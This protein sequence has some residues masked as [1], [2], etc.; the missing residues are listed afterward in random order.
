MQAQIRCDENPFE[1]SHEKFLELVEQLQTTKTRTMQLGELETFVETEGREVLRLMLEEHIRFRGIGDIGPFVKGTDGV[2]RSHRRER[3]I[4]MRTIFGEVTI[5]RLVYG[6]R[7][8]ESLAPKD[9]ALN[10]PEN[11]YSHGLE[12]RLAIEIAKG[13]FDEAI[14]SVKGQTG[15]EIPKRQA[16]EIAARAARDFEVFYEKRSTDAL[17]RTTKEN[18]L[19]V[20]TTDGKGVVMR[21]EDLRDATRK[22]AEKEKKLRTR[23]SK[24][25]KKNAK[26]MAQVASVY[27]IERHERT[28]EQVV[29]GEKSEAPPKPAAKR[30]WASLEREQKDVIGAMFDE[31]ALRDPRHKRDWVVLVDGQPTQLDLIEAEL[32]RRQTNATIVLDVIHVIEYLW[33]ASRDF[34]PE[35]SVEGEEW[36]SRYLM[37]VLEGKAKQVAAAIRRSATRQ[38][39]RKGKREGV[40]ACAAYLHSNAQ[41]LRYDEYLAAGLPIGTGVIEGACRHLVKDRMDITGARWSLGGAEAVL[42]LRSLHASGDYTEY[43][44]YHEA[45]D[46]QC[47]HRSRYANPRQLEGSRLRLVK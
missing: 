37:M 28:A 14:A 8:H 26:R 2:V 30:V 34:Y 45:V 12:R 31:A 7:G 19:V 38:E 36:V 23:L 33:K 5:D 24:G 39:K 43:W 21:K 17:R 42:R 27:S 18:D 41:Y 13:S 4:T 25:E 1:A 6:A 11:G 3:D 44:A 15:V 20:L 40:E 32:K 47:N 16:E 46:Y 35:G 10:L 9:A 29:N 22:R